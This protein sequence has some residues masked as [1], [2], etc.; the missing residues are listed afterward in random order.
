MRLEQLQMILEIA[1]VGSMSQ[2]ARNLSLSQPSLS[3]AVASL[4]KELGLKLFNR[5]SRGAVPTPSGQEVLEIVQQFYTQLA[6]IQQLAPTDSRQP[7]QLKIIAIPSACNTILLEA[8]A[9]FKL[10]Y[11]NVQ[12]LIQQRRSSALLE[13][14]AQSPDAIGIMGYNHM[15][16]ELFQQTLEDTNFV[17]TFLYHDAFHHIVSTANPLAQR[18]CVTLEE[19]YDVPLINFSN[20]SSTDRFTNKWEQFYVDMGLYLP[21]SSRRPPSVITVTSLELTK[22]LVAEN[23]GTTFLPKTALYRDIYAETGRIKALNI[24]SLHMGFDHHLLHHKQIQLTEAV[25][26]LIGIL[27]HIY[28]Q[29]ETA[30]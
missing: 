19:L 11:P 17:T 23:V 6:Q 18:D 14:L 15:Y 16:G 27:K 8:I 25:Q 24:T 20:T 28:H 26:A 3:A 29:L 22:R 10:L 12:I 9:Q 30:E 1:R 5:S 2:A 4:E 7:E 13:E 21:A